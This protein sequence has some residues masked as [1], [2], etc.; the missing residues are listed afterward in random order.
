ML[1]DVFFFLAFITQKPAPSNR[2]Y[3]IKF[4]ILLQCTLRAFHST[5]LKNLA[6]TISKPNFITYNTPLY[7]LPYIKTSN[8]FNT[9]FKYSFFIIFYSSF[10]FLC[11]SLLYV[12]L[13]QPSVAS[14]HIHPPISQPPHPPN[15]AATT[16]NSQKKN[17]PHPKP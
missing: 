4:A 3:A 15:I 16:N 6:F 7:N 12:S 14:H 5:I 17:S 8:F 9:S 13:S 2:V 10:L 11:L 1:K